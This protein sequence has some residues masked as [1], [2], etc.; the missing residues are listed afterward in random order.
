MEL[1][2]IVP[3]TLIAIGLAMIFIELIVGLDSL[4]DLTLSGTSLFFAGV[5]GL[6][7]ESWEAAII[8]SF[9]LLISYW[10]L[11]RAYIHKLIK[12]NPRKT[13]SDKYLDK[14]VTIARVNDKGIAFAKLEGEEWRV[15]TKSGSKLSEGDSVLIQDV[16]GVSLIV[17]KV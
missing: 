10:V 16:K 7:F 17:T 15:E 4:F 9:I 1:S 8:A 3:F 6:F 14:E 2:V 13:N 11:G 5:I 12:T